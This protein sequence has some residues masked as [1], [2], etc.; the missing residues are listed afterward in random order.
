MLSSNW[1]VRLMLQYSDNRVKS[2]SVKIVE[3]E[4]KCI[5]PNIVSKWKAAKVW[6]TV[7]S[8]SLPPGLFV[9]YHLDASL[10][11]R[12]YIGAGMNHAYSFNHHVSTDESHGSIQKYHVYGRRSS[13]RKK[14]L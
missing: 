2:N 1:G 6:M 3:N 8:K 4:I 12:P 11:I 14:R 5:V 10:N 9:R 13:Y 7:D